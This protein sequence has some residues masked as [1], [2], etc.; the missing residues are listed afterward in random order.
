MNRKD[1]TKGL[2][3]L[4]GR[5]RGGE[6]GPHGKGVRDQRQ[7]V[8]KVRAL[9]AEVAKKNEKLA[10][11]Q[12]A[13]D[14]S[15]LKCASFYESVPVACV[16]LDREGLMREANLAAVNLLGANKTK[17][18]GMRCLNYISAE[19]RESFYAHLKR[20]FRTRKLQACEVKVKLKGGHYIFAILN[21]VRAQ[22]LK[23]GAVCRTSIT[24]ITEKA[25]AEAILRETNES[26]RALFDRSFDLIYVHDF[27]GNFIDANPTTLKLLGYKKKEIPA[28]NFA[29]LLEPEDVGRA[30]KVLADLKKTGFQHQMEE[31]KLK[32][33]SGS[34]IYIETVASILYRHKNPYAVQGIARDITRRKFSEQA[35][36]KQ[37]R[38][39]QM[40]IDSI[41][42]P[43]FYKDAKGIYQGCNKAFE[44]FRGLPLKEIVG[45]SVYD[46]APKD[47]AV[48][49][50]KKDRDLFDNPGTQIYEGK[51]LHYD[52]TR[53][54]VLY[55]KATY[56][57]EDG[58]VG[59][60]VGIIH[61]ITDRKRMEKALVEREAQLSEAQHLASIGS[62]NLDVES[63]TLTWS[64]ELYNIFR[65]DPYLPSPTPEERDQIYL[66]ESLAL[67]REAVRRALKS[68][69]PWELLLE[70]V[71]PD[72]T[73]WWG[74]GR[75]SA[76]RDTSGRITRLYG[77]FQDITI[78]KLAAE[79]A[80]KHADDMEFLSRSAMGF[81][82]LPAGKNIFEYIAQCLWEMQPE[83]RIIV[84][85]FD[86]EAN[87]ATVRAVAGAE[88]ILASS[89]KILGRDPVGIETPLTA[90]VKR[91][92]VTQR[93]MLGP[94]GISELS[95]GA[96]PKSVSA[97]LDR[98][99]DIGTV[100]GMG[101]AQ[102][103]TLYGNAVLISP[104]G[105]S[106][107]NAPVVETFI[108]QAAVAVLKY[109]AEEALRE[110][111]KK[112]RELVENANSIILRMDTKGTVTFFNEF[113]Q[114]FF[115][116]ER[117]EIIGRNVVGTIV[118]EID[119][120]GRNQADMI[121]NI[122]RDPEKYSDNENENIK[123]NG[124][125]VWVSWTNKIVRDGSGKK[126]E[127]L[128]IG[129]DST[130]RR[131]AANRL[132]RSLREISV[133]YEISQALAG[134]ESE[135]DVL[136]ALMKRVD[137]YT[138][139]Y[140]SIITFEKT[141]GELTITK[142]RFDPFESGIGT[143]VNFGTCFLVSRHP[144][145]NLLS[146][147]EPFISDN[148]KADGR[149]DEVSREIYLQSDVVSIAVF[150]LTCD[151]DWVGCIMLGSG[152]E[153]YFDDEKQHFYRTLAE[154]G[155][156]ALRHARFRQTIRESQ[157]RLSLLIQ[158]SPLG[159]IEWDV[160]FQV[161]SW[162]TAAERIFGYNFEEAFGRQPAGFI[163]PEDRQ[164]DAMQVSGDFLTQSSGAPIIHDHCTKSG[165]LITC[166]WSSSQLAGADGKATGIVSLV[167]DI[168]GRKLAE[169]AIRESER[170]YRELADFL[171]EIIFELDKELH[172][173]YVNRIA[174]TM[175]GYPPEDLINRET[176]FQNLF[177]PEDHG[178]SKA[179]AQAIISG[180]RS[181]GN[182]YTMLRSDGTRI[183]VMIY[184]RAII[185]NGGVTG[186]RG[187][188]VDI[189]DMKKAEEALRKNEAVLR[190]MLEA[191]PAGVGLLIDRILMKVNISLCKITGYS[192]EEL[193]GRDMQMLYPNKEEYMRV[194]RD[195]Y[196]QMEREGLGIL[197]ADLRRKDGAIIYV[198][199]CLSPFDLNDQSAGVTVTVLDITERKRMDEALKKSEER[200]R[201][202]VESVTDYIYTVEIKD[203]RAVSTVHG[204]GCLAMTGYTSE[205]YTAD[206]ALWSRILHDEDRRAV[207]EQARLVLAGKEAKPLEHRIIHKDG[208]LRWV[209]NTQ[210]LRHDGMG[211]MVA[212]D[213]LI[214]DITERKLAEETLTNLNKQLKEIIEFFPDATFIID[215]DKKIIEWNRAM[216]E[217]TGVFKSDIIGKDHLKATI[218]FY[219]TE[220]PYLMDLVGKD[221]RELALKY[222]NVK[223]KG[224]A[225]LAE[226]FT[227]VLYG[228]RG[229][230]VFAAASP[231]LDRNG[232]VI[233]VIE[234][235]RD[236]T[237]QKEAEAALRESEEKFS[238]AFQYIPIPMAI[239]RIS[240][241][242]FLD[243][244][245]AFLEKYEYP[246][247][248]V[249]GTSAYELPL[250]IDTDMRKK[251]ASL[252][253]TT[254]KI[255]NIKVDLRTRSGKILK[256]IFTG[257]GLI[258]GNV[259]CLLASA[260]DISD[261]EYMTEALRMS[262][263]K[264]RSLFEDSG[265]AQFLLD[266]SWIIDCNSEAVKL[267][268]FGDKA[269][270][271]G[272]DIQDI[273]PPI[274]PDGEP[275]EVKVQKLVASAHERKSEKFEWTHCRNDGDV[276]TA[277]VVLTPIPVKGKEIFHANIRDITERK[278]LQNE[279][280]NII[281]IE[282]QRLGENL[283]DGLGQ[284]LTG[285]AFLC[286]ALTKKLKELK[287][288]EADRAEE[289]TGEVYR[290]ITMLRN[291]SHE[292]YPPNLV[293]NEITYTL[294]DFA[295]K[296]GT[297][298]GITCTFEH[299]PDLVITDIFVSAQVYYIV[300]EAVHNAIKHGNAG[301][302][303]IKLTTEA[304]KVNLTVEDNG[305]GLPDAGERKKGLGLRIMAYRMESIHGTFGITRNRS[306]GTTVYCVFPVYIVSH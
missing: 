217:M 303:I 301:R 304:D 119:S 165:R 147:D 153:S 202:L 6:T 2:S 57:E 34:Y 55:N 18:P 36:E 223:R 52:G 111:E 72:G 231:L 3:P 173:T 177:V 115:G 178:R 59:G 30:Y 302:I 285:I 132:E 280:I 238:T 188:I 279:I 82:D 93:L 84:N 221:D 235:I 179:N 296:T 45:R 195:L 92:M 216:E 101:F 15:R 293:E 240:D 289:I 196:G 79:R 234:S 294:S 203:G 33:K 276:F 159:V 141:G 214:T 185:Q 274:Q 117:N 28:V 74:L 189:T 215:K 140:A 143:A 198:L 288:D 284:D 105:K 167:Q 306:G 88:K 122:S 113:A 124:E 174:Y 96:I 8:R 166:E 184:S 112:Y 193:L 209:R 129:N 283:H 75:G 182:E 51:S 90:Q 239:S 24:D 144:L 199:L 237:E 286:N 247:N 260:I 259:P 273:S 31:Y 154:Q 175:M 87:I 146:A 32:T 60:L 265:D 190:S 257:A 4:P 226:A 100:Y 104:R 39:L 253:G 61:D 120:S 200:F 278:M 47:L 5:K 121:R 162:N 17:L 107:R 20:V 26:F 158:Q 224:E 78:R 151:H 97:M 181:P 7:L 256:S 11:V 300:R 41:P 80:E 77:T 91:D 56:L 263:E 275:S 254:D 210:V 53:H 37:K 192:E 222:S 205:E 76:A 118:P 267:M 81:T 219:G 106:L 69:E 246:K 102:Q 212:S 157:Q 291:L 42:D 271:I 161:V 38:F 207:G 9:E 125:R 180:S 131:R 187:I 62:W 70:M 136:D 241:G 64:E 19:S 134:K 250:W 255:E 63:N 242:V 299:D 171:P 66:P 23:Q 40:I 44:K 54:S 227:P 152:T 10:L 86:N 137:I 139:A 29:S 43:I 138:G 261:I 233:G 236:I 269:G 282:Q 142:L 176:N 164:R 249:I 46:V 50:Y 114:K 211:N 220:R 230:Y 268:G 228:G 67:L 110:S 163:L 149:L 191:M 127:I 169:M 244:N 201:K 150:P 277:E 287:L 170:K 243:V 252:V 155:A 108:K 281:D 13:L 295:S 58:R 290:V 99:L 71:R 225:L 116:F 208:S 49:Y 186:I 12:A 213:G 183:P 25:S 35:L 168:T 89:R 94:T 85:E 197:E 135:D 160:D 48:L 123:K 298:F 14:E 27:K 248:E 251:L 145:I 95:G 258:I 266:G 130:D 172:I 148:I 194:G 245:R 1:D 98:I 103:D 133:R 206:P 297:L 126:Q 229:A 73:R 270:L 21:S 83:F 204:P 218:P 16:T 68:G 109:K 22:G 262:E 232:D 292:L 156:A 65:R 272:K 264:F 128:C 305:T